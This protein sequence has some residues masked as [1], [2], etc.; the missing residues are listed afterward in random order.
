MKRPWDIG[1]RITWR[2]NLRCAMCDIW[3]VRGREE[4]D[5]GE[6]LRIVDEMKA[7]G[8]EYFVLTG[9]EPLLRD[10]IFRIIEYASR[11]GIHV[12]MTTNGAL[13][14]RETADRLASAG[15]HSVDVSI[16]GLEAANDAVRGLPGAFRKADEAL[17]YL[18]R[19]RGLEVWV[20]TVVMDSNLEDLLPLAVRTS[21]RGI[22]IKFQ[23]VVVWDLTPREQNLH[24]R[25]SPLWVPE[26][27]LSLLDEVIDGIVEFKRARGSVNNPVEMLRAFKTYFRGDFD[28]PCIKGVSMALDSNG[29]LLPCWYWTPAGNVRGRSL[30]EVWESEALARAFREMKGCRGKCILNCHFPAD[31]IDRGFREALRK[32][33]AAGEKGETG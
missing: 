15:L 32:T 11:L 5:T 22:P 20:A 25:S 19:H 26:E 17:G 31:P 10:D 8:V 24:A 12:C 1:L 13:V 4:M 6:V 23:P 28:E 21:D 2:C 3:K 30:K 18:S 29:D 27:R 14:D 33:G 9:G 7:W 16:D